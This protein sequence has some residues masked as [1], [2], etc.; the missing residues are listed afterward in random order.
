MYKEALYTKT[1][2][3][4]RK[5]ENNQIL[6]TFYLAGGTAL[7]MQLG[8]RKSI[9]LDFFSSEFPKNELIK[10]ALKD[11]N[12]KIIHEERGTL[13]FIIDDVKV[14]FLEY[15]Y[16]LIQDFVYFEGLKMAQVLDLACMKVTA[17][18]SRGSKKDFVDL[19]FVLREYTFEEIFD[20]FAKKYQGVNYQKIHMLKSLAFF[21]DAEQD[22]EPDYLVPADWGEIKKDLETKILDFVNG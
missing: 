4:L 11:Y 12:P 1:E 3:V 16:P 5:I 14:S 22:P 6:E 13:D 15:K 7:A 8:H 9:D 17:V 21:D 20:Y 2:Q 10:Q 19:Y 18:S